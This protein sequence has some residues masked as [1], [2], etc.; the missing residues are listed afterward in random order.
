[1]LTVAFAYTL[2]DLAPKAAARAEK[3]T[4]LIVKEAGSR[5]GQSYLEE[6]CYCYFYGLN[7]ACAITCRSILEEVIERKLPTRVL[8]NW[9][10]EQ[11]QPEA[12]PTLGVLLVLSKNTA[13]K[14]GWHLPPSAYKPASTVLEVGN[15][16]AH[17]E[18]IVE[19]DAF[20]C[21]TAAREAIAAILGDKR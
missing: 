9:R 21:M 1:M 12:Q 6:A 10:Q 11:S 13:R 5:E 7:T 2:I 3:I 20:R 8:E 4:D 19:A 15:R 16:A 14:A 18:P 17:N